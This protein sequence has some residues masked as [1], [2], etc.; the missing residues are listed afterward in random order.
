MTSA[1]R[2]QIK[3]CTFGLE[4]NPLTHINPIRPLV[5]WY[6]SRR[7][8]K[9][10][11]RELENSYTKNRGN[12]DKKSIVS[13][14]L[15]FYLEES[16]AK[17][18]NEIDK[19]FKEFAASQMKLF[20]FA[21]HDTTATTIC[22]VYHLL[23]RNPS[24]LRKVRAEHDM[25]FGKDTTRIISIINSEPHL[26]NQLPY[27]L[28]VI[29]ETLRLFPVVTIP[30]AGHP[31][32]SLTD[33]EGCKYPTKDCLVWGN[34]H[35]LHRNPHW[36]PQ[37]DSFIPERWLVHDDDPLYPVKNA[38]RPFEWGPRNCI[39]QELALLE[40]KMIAA[41]T[42][43]DFN[44][45]GAYEEWDR[46]HGTKNANKTVNGERAYQIQLGSAHPS[47]GFPCRVTLAKIGDRT[48]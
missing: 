9:Y 5:H 31:D 13:L 39:G 32:I 42:I 7:M 12:S 34:H 10:I 4:P 15:K 14:A 16:A 17:G 1:L 3:W 23:S 41:L 47:D 33:S 8:N 29:K 35:A 44:V 18:K 19:T 45:T 30:R 6:N 11:N 48:D 27:T 20:L 2:E 22:Y 43:R 36:W 28:A 24:A 21:G 37:P 40:M 38:W 25:V 46:L 26:L